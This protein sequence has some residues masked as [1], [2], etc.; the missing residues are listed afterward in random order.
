MICEEGPWALSRHTHL[1][2]C[3]R[4]EEI[5]H[6]IQSPWR[7]EGWALVLFC[8]GEKGEEEALTT[9]SFMGMWSEIA[10]AP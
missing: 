9:A 6:A 5:K 7:Q 8:V 1:F 2:S 4:V 10:R 3:Q